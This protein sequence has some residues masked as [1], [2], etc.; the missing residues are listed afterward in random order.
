M[1]HTKLSEKTRTCRPGIRNTS[2]STPRGLSTPSVALRVVAI[3]YRGVKMVKYSLTIAEVP[4]L[5]EA[6]RSAQT[7]GT[8]VG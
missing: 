3:V 2:P 5:E 1:N 7:R 6:R 8:R 4:A